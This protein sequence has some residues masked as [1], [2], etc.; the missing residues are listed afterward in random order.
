MVQPPVLARKPGKLPASHASVAYTLEYGE[1][2]M[3]M[4]VDSIKPGERIVL[5]DDLLAYSRLER[6]ELK[7]DRIELAPIING[8][9][10]EKKRESVFDIRTQIR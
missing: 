8:L 5:I 4:H 9:V 2:E 3:E 1:A 10:Q 6:R 7:T